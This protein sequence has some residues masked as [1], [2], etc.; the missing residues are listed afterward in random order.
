M[1]AYISNQS[2]KLSFH[3]KTDYTFLYFSIYGNRPRGRFDNVYNIRNI[4]SCCYRI[5][6]KTFYR[7]NFQVLDIG[8]SG[9][10]DFAFKSI[11]KTD[12]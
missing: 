9:Q 12:C 11:K 8:F 3:F 2:L 4:G 5:Y 1:N 7:S 6:R 10:P